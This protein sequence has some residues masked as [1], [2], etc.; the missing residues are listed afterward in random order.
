MSE[1]ALQDQLGRAVETLLGELA[2]VLDQAERLAE[3]VLAGR[4][5][6]GAQ[7]PKARAE[8]RLIAARL[9]VWESRPVNAERRRAVMR[10]LAEWRADTAG[11]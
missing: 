6:D 11:L 1:H 7:G 2:D 8:A 9:A 5:S 10:A 4:P 3:L